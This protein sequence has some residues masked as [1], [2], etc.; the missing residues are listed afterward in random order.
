MTH[1]NRMRTVL[2]LLT[3]LAIP[4]IAHTQDILDDVVLITRAKEVLAFSSAGNQWIVAG[5]RAQEQVVES[6]TGSRVAVVVT[7]QRALGF[8]SVMNRWSEI[9]IDVGEQVLDMEA[10]GFVSSV[11]TNFRALGFGAGKGEWTEYRYR[12]R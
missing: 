12:Y 9:K 10:K 7:N 8:S 4:T 1:N 5:L 3:F 11:D 6:R 2:A